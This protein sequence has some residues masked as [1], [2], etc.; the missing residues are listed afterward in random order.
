MTEKHKMTLEI[1]DN[2]YAGILAFS[3][4]NNIKDSGEAVMELVKHAL[5][6]PPYFKNFDWERAEQEADDEISSGT[7]ME[8]SDVDSFL[9]ELNS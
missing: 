7:L 5:N 9:N 4:N 8:F 2:I 6:L 3:R 1:P